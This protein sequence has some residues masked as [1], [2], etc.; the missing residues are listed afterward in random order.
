MSLSGV[1]PP[2]VGCG[3][4]VQPDGKCKAKCSVGV[5]RVGLVKTNKQLAALQRKSTKATEGAAVGQWAVNLASQGSLVGKRRLDATANSQTRHHKL[6]RDTP[7]TPAVAQQG[8]CP[9]SAADVSSDSVAVA[10]APV[11]PAAPTFLSQVQQAR[12]N[13]MRT[14]AEIRAAEETDRAAARAREAVVAENHRSLMQTIAETRDEQAGAEAAAQGCPNLVKGKKCDRHGKYDGSCA[15][16]GCMGG[17]PAFAALLEE[18]V[19]Q[20]EDYENT[21]GLERARAGRR[22]ICYGMVAAMYRSG[23]KRIKLK[24][25]LVA[26]IRLRYPSPTSTYVGHK[27]KGED[28]RVSARGPHQ[29]VLDS[30]TEY[31]DDEE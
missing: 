30:D 31:D 6:Q 14:V 29:S 12:Q 17:H 16:T 2:P 20:I 21:A 19:P 26:L 23:K 1:C 5:V 11:P 9:A 8:S 10:A 13:G 4:P 7:A 15:P 22:Y 24:A 28:W 3:Q 27:P 25:C 18:S